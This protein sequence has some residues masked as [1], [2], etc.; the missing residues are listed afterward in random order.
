MV[1]WLLLSWLIGPGALWMFLFGVCPPLYN[2]IVLARAAR[3][4]HLPFV[5]QQR[6]DQWCSSETLPGEWNR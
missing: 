5:R 3:R 6:R 4:G 1:K 2:Q